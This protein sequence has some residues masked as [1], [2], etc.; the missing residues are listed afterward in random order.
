MFADE[1]AGD[2]NENVGRKLNR[3]IYSDLFRSPGA[4]VVG[5]GLHE[6][7]HSLQSVTVDV[8]GPTATYSNLR[9]WCIA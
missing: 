6:V 7:T 4:C 3:R 9:V 1:G 8:Q 5:L 2:A